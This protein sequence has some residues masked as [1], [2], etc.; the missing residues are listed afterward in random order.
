MRWSPGARVTASSPAPAA[1]PVVAGGSRGPDPGGRGRSGADDGPARGAGAGAGGGGHPQRRGV[2]RLGRGAAAVREISAEQLAVAGLQPV[3]RGAEPQLQ[4]RPF[5]VGAGG[6]A[7]TG[8]GWR[9]W[10]TTTAGLSRARMRVEDRSLPRLHLSRRRRADQWTVRGGSLAS[11]G[12][13]GCRCGCRPLRGAGLRGAGERGGSCCPQPRASSA[14]RGAR[15][16]SAAGK[17]DAGGLLRD[18]LLHSTNLTAEVVGLAA[19]VARGLRPHA[20][21][22]GAGHDRWIR[23]ETGRRCGSWTIRGWGARAGSRRRRWRCARAPRGAGPAAADPEDIVLTDRAGEALG[24]PRGRAG[25]RRGR[26][27]SRPRWRAT[28]GR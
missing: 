19:S 2:P 23:E 12:S 25:E 3:D 26:S 18:M 24:R 4:P 6:D 14:A 16:R 28:C 27:T 5:R 11:G 13:R 22:V 8:C 20:R 7:S 15:R 21:R 1:G 9:R 10:G 17:R